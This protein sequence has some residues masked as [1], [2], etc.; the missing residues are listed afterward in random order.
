MALHASGH[1]FTGPKLTVALVG[2]CVT[3][4]LVQFIAAIISVAVKNDGDR[5][6]TSLVLLILELNLIVW[7]G[8]YSDRNAGNAVKELEVMNLL[9][10]QSISIDFNYA[11]IVVSDFFQLTAR[12]REAPLPALSCIWGQPLIF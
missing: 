8:Y 3:P 6:Y 12:T 2:I 4:Q 5:G 7:V 9:A 10:K 11:H 1:A